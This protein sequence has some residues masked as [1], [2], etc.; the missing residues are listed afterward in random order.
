M[1]HL[2]FKGVFPILQTPF[3]EKREISFEGVRKETEWLIEQGVDGIG[4]AIA[5]EVFKLNDI[6]KF[7]LLSAVVD[8]SAGR[9][10]IIMNTGQESTEYTIYMSKKAQELGAQ[11]LMI[12]P[13]VFDKL[14]KIYRGSFHKHCKGCEYSYFFFRI[15]GKSPI[16][17]ESA[18]RLS[19]NHEI[20]HILN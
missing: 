18:V 5:S 6:E 2:S 15:R 9:V 16:S 20:F 7:E 8:Q 10:P 12:K 13:P 4:I 19:K 14:P 3:N 1:R 11:G 17:G